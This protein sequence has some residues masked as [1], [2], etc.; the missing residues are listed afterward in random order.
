MKSRDALPLNNGSKMK[1]TIGRALIG[2]G[3]ILFVVGTVMRRMVPR[4]DIPNTAYLGIYGVA[5]VVMGIGYVV[6]KRSAP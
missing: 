1:A 2:A 3:L 6:K 5:C 4:D